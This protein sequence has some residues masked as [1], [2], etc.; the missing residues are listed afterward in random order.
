M[1]VLW[2][3]NTPC[4]AGQKLGNKSPVGGWL[5]SLQK[6]LTELKPDIEL[7]IAFLHSEQLEKFTFDSCEF[8]PIFQKNTGSKISRFWKRL[9]NYE[10]NEFILRQITPIINQFKPDVIHIHGTEE[11]FGLLQDI[12][13][14]PVVISIQGLINPYIEKYYSGISKQATDKNE[15]ISSKLLLNS[16]S[17]RYANFL[18]KAKR[19]TQ[20]M[21]LT[22]NLIGRT[23]WDR[24][25]SKVI[26]PGSKYFFNNEILRDSFYSA[27]W[28]NN[29]ERSDNSFKIIT[30]AGDN[31]YK[32]FETI[33]K[34][35]MLLK[36]HTNL[37]FEWIV[38]GVNKDSKIVQL[39]EKSLRIDLKLT[40]IIFAGKKNETE[41]ISSF[42]NVDLYCQVSHIENSP[43]SLCEA[44]ILGM[45]IIA[46][47]A[48]GTNSLIEN[49]K[50]G[51][52]VQDGDHY[53]LAGAILECKDN[54]E[55]AIRMSINAR[56][57][58]LKRHDPIGITDDLV[59][60]YNCII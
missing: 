13:T 57:R 8:Y 19:E 23:D 40:G 54:Y 28:K 60:I 5:V 14:V 9:V 37:L 51:I 36:K 34:T 52:L 56:T 38:V 45:P 26:A 42:L 29:L 33:V 24:R 32:G 15:K 10:D 48:G 1:K 27:A 4:S 49:N 31:L 21:H 2:F 6:Q 3:T 47:F 46:T 22:K 50:E 43:N 55:N 35:C 53:S 25:V 44:M 20:I 58:A 7:G 12:T 41:I 18:A 59:K 11:C 16:Y 39:V 17:Y 30:T